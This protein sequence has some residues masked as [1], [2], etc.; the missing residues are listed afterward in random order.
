MGRFV[1]ASGSPRRR[2]LLRAAG[3]QFE[4]LKP[5]ADELATPALTPG[6]LTFFNARQKGAAA[7]RSAKSA[8]VLAADTVVSLDGDVLGKPGDMREAREFLRRL[9]GRAHEVYSSVFIVDAATGQQH[10]FTEISVVRFR[11]LDDSAITAYLTKIDPLDKAG[12]YAA[13]GNSSD[14]IERVDGS[15]TN[16]VGLPMEKTQAA[17]A[18]FGIVPARA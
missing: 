3:Y 6:E 1:L 15:F 7:C 17:L 14:I 11:A 4:V 5:D 18:A 2:E 12:G 8:V 9:S 13:Q 10:I 16:V